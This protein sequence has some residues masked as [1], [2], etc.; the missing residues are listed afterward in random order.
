MGDALPFCLMAISCYGQ[1]HVAYAQSTETATWR[2]HGFGPKR[3]VYA[4]LAHKCIM[5][6]QSKL[7]VSRWSDGH[8]NSV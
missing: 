6:A 2:L 5:F 1:S 3:N 4:A 7:Q 8:V